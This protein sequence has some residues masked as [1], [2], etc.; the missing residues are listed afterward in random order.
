M[1]DDSGLLNTT[2]RVNIVYTFDGTLDTNSGLDFVRSISDNKW[3]SFETSGSTPWMAQFTNAWGLE[4]KEGRGTHY[5]NDYLW[6]PLGDPYGF[7]MYN[8]YIYKNSGASNSGEHNRVMT[9][10]AFAEDQPVGMTD[11]NS[12]DPKDDPYNVYELL[13]GST[14]GYFYVHPVTN[15]T[16]TKYYLRAKEYDEVGKKGTFVILSETP[17]NFTFGLS[18]EL[19]KPYFDLVGY[20]GGLKENVAKSEDY[21]DKHINVK[22]LATAIKNGTPLTAL[23]L[24]DA[25]TLVYDDANLVPFTSGYYR[26]HSPDGIAGI[27]GIRYASGYTHLIESTDYD[28]NSTADAD[29]DGNPAVDI[30]PM[31]FYEVEGTA[32]QFNL[33]KSKD[34]ERVNEGFTS[35]VATRGDIPI[36]AAESDP[37]SIFY[38]TGTY[39]NAKIQTQGLYVKGEVGK[40]GDDGNPASTIEAEGVRAKAHMTSTVGSASE[41]W[42]MDIGGGVMLIHDRSIPRYRKYLSYDQTDAAH[43]YDLKL[44]HNTHTDHAKWCLQPA[45]NLGL[46]ITTHSGGDE[47]T[48]GTAYNYST[49]YA[50]FDILLPDDEADKND[51]S[52]NAKQYRAFICDTKISPWNDTELHPRPISWYNIEENN[53]PEDYRGSM[54][55]VPAGT[56]VILAAIDN[57][58][59]DYIKV[60]IPTSA[61][62]TSASLAEDFKVKLNGTDLD[63]EERDNTLTGQYLEQKLA[64]GDKGYVYVFGLPYTGTFTEDNYASNGDI[65]ATLPSP[66]N[67][68]WGFYKNINPN[69]EASPARA[70]WTRNNWYVLGNKAYYRAAGGGS[71]R[72]MTRGGVDFVP[73]VFDWGEYEIGEGQSDDMTESREYVGDGCVYDMQGRRVATEEQVINGTWK[74]RVSPGIYIINGKK[75]SVN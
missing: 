71:A 2:V 26:M 22:S 10:T 23:Q 35:S 17:T 18:D 49:F 34:G 31:H 70:S 46:K 13:S 3:Y 11:G 6:S 75:I 28:N 64:A 37:A 74:Q 66:S 63:N 25:Q 14:D 51:P 54:K 20:V 47:G 40:T 16:G 41:L 42:I 58:D 53:C 32:T 69:K 57:S 5:T 65:I 61:P 68:G 7:R 45:N 67:S 43:I 60:T 9:T 1:G 29:G 19:V 27:D 8:R 21:G 48:Y 72:G 39:D 36:P 15:D 38:I 52:K 4:V 73:V 33:L 30:L 44:T 12:T 62:S 24:M 56:P 59:S 55:F 50:P